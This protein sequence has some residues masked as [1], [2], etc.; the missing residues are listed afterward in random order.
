MPYMS[1]IELANS[2]REINSTVKIFLITAF[3]IDDIKD[4]KNYQD[5]KIDKIIQKPIKFS[6]SKK[7]IEEELIVHKT[8]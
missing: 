7:L 2:I 6:M 1:G 5:A 4:S 3:D 8:P